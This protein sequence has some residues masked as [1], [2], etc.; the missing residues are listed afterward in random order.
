MNRVNLQE[1]QRK[2][3]IRSYYAPNYNPPKCI[4]PKEQKQN[5]GSYHYIYDYDLRTFH[6]DFLGYLV[7]DKSHIST[8]LMACG[9]G[10]TKILQYMDY[11][12]NGIIQNQEYGGSINFIML[13][14]NFSLVKFCITQGKRSSCSKYEDEY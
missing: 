14:L 2:L 8:M 3:L 6:S 9:K 7:L 1:M 5:E 13:V 4:F 12:V 11:C 10:F